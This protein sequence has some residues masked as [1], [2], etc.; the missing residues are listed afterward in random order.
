MTSS[1]EQ[2]LDI[3]GL[4][5][6]PESMATPDVIVS[7]P[8]ST[9]PFISNL[10]PAPPTLAPSL[11]SQPS[12]TLSFSAAEYR[13]GE[14]GTPIIPVTV[15]RTG[16]GIG[17]VSAT[18]NLLGGTATVFQ[19]YENTPVVV[20]FAE[21]ETEKIVELPLNDDELSEG[22]ES[23]GLTLTNPINAVI[24]PQNTANLT[25]ID[26]EVPGNIEFASAEF[27]TLEVDIPILSV[28]VVRT[29]GNLGPVS[30]TINLTDET[31]TALQ[32]YDNT[33][34]VVNFADGEVETVV[35]VPIIDD[36]L[37]EGIETVNLTLANPVGGAGLGTQ[38]TAT[39]KIIDNEVSSVISVTPGD[40]VSAQTIDVFLKPGEELTIPITVTVPG[41]PSLREI[42]EINN[43]SAL[44]SNSQVSQQPLNKLPLDVFLLQ[45]LS[46]SFTEDLPIIK[47]LIPDLLNSIQTQQP[48]SYFGVG[49]FVDKPIEPL[50]FAGDYVYN[51]E[52]SLTPFTGPIESVVENFTT[53]KGNDGPEAQLEALLQTALR[54]NN[55]GFRD[56]ARHAVVVATDDTFHVKGD[57][58]T[59]GITTPNNLDA[60]LDGDPPG[61]GE[62]YPSIKEVQRELIR[63]DILP[64]FTVTSDILSTYQNLVNNE[65]GFGAVTELSVDSSNLV[66]AITEGIE[67]INSQ[68]NIFAIEDENGFIQGISQERFVGVLPGESRTFNVTLRT[69]E[70]P[71]NGSAT[72]RALGFGD[73]KI[74]IITGLEGP[75]VGI[76]S[77]APNY[78]DQLDVIGTVTGGV[79]DGML[80][81]G[82]NPNERR[83]GFREIRNSAGETQ[84]SDAG[85]TWVI[86]HGWNDN[87]GGNFEEIANK[88]KTINPNDQVLL[89]DWREASNNEANN[90]GGN[91]GAGLSG[92]NGDAAT[93]IASVAQ[94]AVETLRD[95]YGIDS[96]EA[97][98]NLNLIGHSLGSLLSSEI[99]RIYREGSNRNGE[100]IEGIEPNREGVATITAL[101]PPSQGAVLRGYD[102]N[103]GANLFDSIDSPEQFRDTSR[104]SRAFV[105]SRSVAGNPEFAGWADQS[106]Q[107][108]F[109]KNFTV[110][111][112]SEA[113]QLIKLD[114]EG[115]VLFGAL[116]LELD[117]GIDVGSEHTRVVQTFNNLLD[118]EGLIGNLLGISSYES[119]Q[120]LDIQEFDNLPIR[121]QIHEGIIEVNDENQST[122]LIASANSENS[123]DDIVIGN[124]SNDTLDGSS[125]I[126]PFGGDWRFTGAGNDQLFGDDGD[127]KLQG[128]SGNDTLIGGNG[129][130]TLIGN[131]DDDILIGGPGKDTLDGGGGSN[132]FVF[133]PTDNLPTNRDE[134]DIIKG[135]ETNFFGGGQDKIGLVGDLWLNRDQI[136]FEPIQGPGLF[137]GI[138]QRTVAVA[139][140]LNDQYLAVFERD[141][142]RDEVEFVE[143]NLDNF[144]IT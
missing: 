27:S 91:L 141:I 143:V 97:L 99:G 132:T 135:F 136:E 6:E 106:F 47:E 103:G 105:G 83:V 19:D 20:N 21:G 22:I 80:I 144:M 137:F 85:Q 59:A 76:P 48:D 128:D 72:L 2:F 50:G 87:I 17:E 119:S 111:I 56:G 140:S 89:L 88:I 101:D 121:G 112:S 139:M 39:L 5:S 44:R 58:A 117:T 120:G 42:S 16:E 36:E 52:L 81:D 126:N 49:S 25:L 130:D 110:G 95:V 32:D 45:D 62:D 79:T 92:G 51:T 3:F 53:F 102:V 8:I 31:G 70:T 60:I 13:L 33:P 40:L 78:L 86:T 108:D 116:D 64:I 11:V 4:E 12:E 73:T 125:N 38:N 46:F 98:Q 23:V 123:Q 65:F 114:T 71:I 57:G 129:N 61:T 55:I 122:F 100:N 15:I 82:V 107:M 35:A 94:F 10:P 66:D 63:A 133:A 24:G 124:T 1:T 7:S 30:A 69:G 104:F 142:R 75:Y 127:D 37:A 43:T 29:D 113:N 67:A 93:W 28:T 118:Q 115:L 41:D 54:A 131:S 96:Q 68:I 90:S 9:Q 77:N 34:I 26:E 109:T 74:N 14:D 138:G 18:V 134:A 84:N